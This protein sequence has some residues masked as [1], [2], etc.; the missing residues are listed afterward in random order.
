MVRFSLVMLL[1]AIPALGQEPP[2]PAGALAR[3]GSPRL[4]H[5]AG[6]GALVY[7]ADGKLLATAT[8]YNAILVHDPGTGQIRHRFTIDPIA[9]PAVGLPPGSS[10]VTENNAEARLNA[11][12]LRFSPDGRRLFAGSNGVVRVYRIDNGKL[13]QIRLLNRG[14][15]CL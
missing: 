7:S 5:G 15:P 8:E 12:V 13:D 6:V 14:E 10:V 1:L 11:T 4:R 3:V 9:R 2:L